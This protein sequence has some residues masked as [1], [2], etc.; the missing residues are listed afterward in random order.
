LLA[1]PAL[2]LIVALPAGAA[3]ARRSIAVLAPAGG[4]G[5]DAGTIEIIEELIVGA[6]EGGGRFKAISRSDVNALLGHERQKLALGC[7]EDAACI[8]EIAG[9]L[10]ADFL[11]SPGI[12]RMGPSIITTLKIIDVHAAAVMV[13]VQRTIKS[14]ADL[15]DGIRALVEEAGK[16]FDAKAAAAPVVAAAAAKDGGASAKPALA[17]PAPAAPAGAIA[18][19]ADPAVP[20]VDPSPGTL[21]RRVMRIAPWAAAGVVAVAA[22]AGGWFGYSAVEAG[23]RLAL[24][25]DVDALQ[26]AKADAAFGA[27][28]ANVSFGVAGAAAVAGGV[29]WWL[30]RGRP[31]GSGGFVVEAEF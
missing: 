31:A 16:A 2:A 1:A 3:P 4:A 23:R 21:R 22:G 17:A 25:P 18:A 28:A 30:G 15:P 7:Q 6:L 26:R 10:G 9:A 13:R 29:L 27:T 19:V 24:A 12:A 20:P 11:A 14:D 5:F 8:A